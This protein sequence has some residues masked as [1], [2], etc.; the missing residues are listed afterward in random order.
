MLDL[1]FTLDLAERHMDNMFDTRERARATAP[2]RRPQ[3]VPADVRPAARPRLQR[4]A[5]AAF[6]GGR[7]GS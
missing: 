6:A 3:A 2:P 4:L 5:R 7:A 1:L